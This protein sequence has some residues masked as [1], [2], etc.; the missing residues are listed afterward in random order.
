MQNTKGRENLK[1]TPCSKFTCLVSLQPIVVAG[2]CATP[3][4][5]DS[6]DDIEFHV[7]TGFLYIHYVLCNLCTLLMVM[8]L[9]GPASKC[10]AI[11]SHHAVHLIFATVGR[12]IWYLLLQVRYPPKNNQ[13]HTEWYAKNDDHDDQVIKCTIDDL[14]GGISKCIH[15]QVVVATLLFACWAG[16]CALT[17]CMVDTAKWRQFDK[18]RLSKAE[19]EFAE[20]HDVVS[21]A[22][23]ELAVDPGSH[24]LSRGV[25]PGSEGFK[26]GSELFKQ[27]SK[28]IKRLPISEKEADWDSVWSDPEGCTTRLYNP[29]PCPVSVKHAE[30]GLGALTDD[31]QLDGNSAEAKALL[32]SREQDETLRSCE[33]RVVDSVTGLPQNPRG[34]TGW[35][36]RG[37][38][39]KFGA[40]Q[41][42]DPF[43]WRVNADNV[44]EVAVLI[45]GNGS[46]SLP[47][48][49]PPAYSITARTARTDARTTR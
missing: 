29:P 24:K 28:A 31:E 19:D 46:Y 38:L 44:L 22:G 8:D 6:A 4:L 10:M 42:V 33:R 17:L 20:E 39:F 18:S 35:C 5:M 1:L 3:G 32:A 36:G 48:Y 43:M 11:G 26:K 7:A 47:V 27:S 25:A 21:R 34:R 45:D 16:G 15:L 12:Y 2:I 49:P 9:A 37:E 30:T 41:A 23:H 40:N 14:A 13:N